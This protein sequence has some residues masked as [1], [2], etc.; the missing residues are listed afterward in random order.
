L[1]V[2]GKVSIH[3]VKVSMK[4]RRSLMCLTGGILVKSSCRS[5]PGKWPLAWW[6]GEERRRVFDRGLVLEH[7]LQKDEISFSVL[8]KLGL[9]VIRVLTAWSKDKGLEWKTW[10]GAVSMGLICCSGRTRVLLRNQHPLCWLATWAF[11]SYTSF[12]CVTIIA[13]DLC[14]YAAWTW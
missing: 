13:L 6:V 3:P 14:G 5:D 9:G 4:T 10:W 2:V 8:W 12:L 7:M 11:N 1:L